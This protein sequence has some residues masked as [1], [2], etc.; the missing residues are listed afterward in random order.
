MSLVAYAPSGTVVLKVFVTSLIP[1][2]YHH[3][4]RIVHSAYLLTLVTTHAIVHQGILIGT[5]ILTL[6]IVILILV[7]IT[8]HVLMALTAILACVLMDILTPTV[9]LILMN[10]VL[11]H[12]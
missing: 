10:A 12:V 6:M 1:A 11:S 2:S 5:V 4:A 3:H 9:L 7:R 8:V